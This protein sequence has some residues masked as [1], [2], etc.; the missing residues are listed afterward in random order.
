MAM[1]C[2]SISLNFSTAYSDSNMAYRLRPIPLALLALSA[3]LYAAAP[4]DVTGAGAGH[5]NRH[6]RRQG[7]GGNAGDG[8]W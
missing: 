3:P 5:G 1:R 8:G 6:P 2:N 7:A 4:T